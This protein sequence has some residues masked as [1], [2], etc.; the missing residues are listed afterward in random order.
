MMQ[1]IMVPFVAATLLLAP[2]ASV[3]DSKASCLNAGERQALQSASDTR[4][5]GLRAGDETLPGG[6]SGAER[7]ELARAQA[8]SST[9]GSQRA[10]D[11]TL[12]DRDLTIIG[13][14]VLVVIVIAIVA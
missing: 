3:G 9:L 5:G 10:G 7:A 1:S 13:I 4:L 11:V 8:V 2:A 6:F 12:S 14:V